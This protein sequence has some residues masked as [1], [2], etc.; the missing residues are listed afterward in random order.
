L[1][2]DGKKAAIGVGLVAIAGIAVYV[3]TRPAE[4]IPPPPPP[5]LANLYG[6][7]TDAVTGNAIPGVLVTL[8]GVQAYTDSGGNYGFTN[9]DPRSYHVT[10]QKEGYEVS[11]KDI[12]IHEGD[13][14]LNIQMVPIVVP[15]G[16]A[17]LHGVVTDAVTGDPIAGVKVTIDGT[18]AYTNAGG[19]YG[20]TGLPPGSYVVTFEKEGYETATR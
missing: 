12:T 8:D 18:T 1:A 6:K 15:P 11:S 17:T 14:P 19:E 10:L 9:I 7:V 20:F 2:T 4:A 5:G 3:A 16:E 13:N